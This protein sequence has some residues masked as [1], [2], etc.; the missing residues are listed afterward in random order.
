MDL[1]KMRRRRKSAEA[2]AGGRACEGRNAK[3]RTMFCSER[4]SQ[5]RT[6][7]SVPVHCT[8]FWNEDGKPKSASENGVTFD[9][10]ESGLSFFSNSRLDEGRGIAVRCR[11]V[12]HSNRIGTVKWCRSVT[13]NLHKV[14]VSLE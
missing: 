3:E 9:I 1:L 2:F 10:S 12:W 6:Q 5:K 14:G 8:S 4:R 13:F 11:D 7:M